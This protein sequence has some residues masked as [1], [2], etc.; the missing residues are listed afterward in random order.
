VIRLSPARR[1]VI[2][3]IAFPLLVT[4]SATM[5]VV[6]KADQVAFESVRTA[7]T[8]AARPVLEL[9]SRPAA[10]FEKA[11]A[12]LRDLVFVY[13]ENARLVQTNESLLGWQQAALELA[14]ENAQL[15]EL[16]KLVPEPPGSYVTAR[17]I[18]DTGGAYARSVIVNA[19]HD[20]GVA[21]GQA[22]VAAEGLVG[23]VSEVGRRTARI[24]LLT[25]LNSRVP[26]VIESSRRRAILVGDDSAQ[27]S[28]GY[29]DA[30]AVPRVGD[31]IL[32]LGQGGIFPPG[33]PVGVI[34][35]FDGELPRVEPYAALS[36][37][38]YLRLLDYGLADALPDPLPV[39]PRSGKRADASGDSRAV[40]R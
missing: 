26:V 40:R 8:D 39:G 24:L 19:G 31:R 20:N 13:R 29:R 28:L 7:V 15:R 1:A 22:A 34:V 9:S 32:T 11:I 21:R 12:R 38:D 33:L 23:R 17:V 36:R 10:A 35:R 27:P 3:R 6:G 37:L 5:I 14:A 30:G 25:D 16:L 4:M 18:A 2:E